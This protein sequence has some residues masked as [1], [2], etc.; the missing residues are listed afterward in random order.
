ML[1]KAIRKAPNTALGYHG[2]LLRGLDPAGVWRS[3][4]NST[5]ILILQRKKKVRRAL[6]HTE[7]SAF[8]LPHRNQRT[9]H[10]LIYQAAVSWRK[11][12]RKT[13]GNVDILEKGEAWL[14]GSSW[15]FIDRHRYSAS[16]S[17][18]NFEMIE[19]FRDASEY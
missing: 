13:E 14:D 19:L 18:N 17:K 5:D 6:S 16:Q 11:P 7:T 15:I 12:K 3:K 8:A 9:R 2:K 4:L 1:H 10:C